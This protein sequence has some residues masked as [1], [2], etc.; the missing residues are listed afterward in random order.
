MLKKICI[1]AATAFALAACGGQAFAGTPT[2]VTNSAGTTVYGTE[3]ALSV[4]KDTSAG[5]NRVKVKYGSGFQYVGDDGAWSRYAALKAGLTKA[6]D[7]PTSVTGLA[8]DVAKSNGVY[9][10][11]G[12][13]LIAWPNVGM[14]ETIADS[15]SFF[16]AVKAVS[17]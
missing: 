15:C 13:S 1:L 7:A 12:S 6:V 5:Y 16:N 14:A 17:P 3:Q 11:S 9:C 10:Q 2:S 8:Y 4:E